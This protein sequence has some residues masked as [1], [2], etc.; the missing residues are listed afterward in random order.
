VCSGRGGLFF[1]SD[2]P[3]SCFFDK[4]ARERKRDHPALHGHFVNAIRPFIFHFFFVFCSYKDCSPFPFSMTCR[5]QYIRNSLQPSGVHCFCLLPLFMQG[6]TGLCFAYTLIFSAILTVDKP[7]TRQK[8]G[9]VDGQRNEESKK[10]RKGRVLIHHDD[11]SALLVPT[12]Q[13]AIQSTPPPSKCLKQ[14]NPIL[15]SVLCFLYA[16]FLSTTTTTTTTKNRSAGSSRLLQ[17]A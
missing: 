12:I 5:M 4:G 1:I 10:R 13:F 11:W 7:K 15:T 2:I 14:S 3:E 16:I 8:K 9:K 17:H 6:W